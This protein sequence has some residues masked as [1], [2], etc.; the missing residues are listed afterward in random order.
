MARVNSPYSTMAPSNEA[1]RSKSSN[2]PMRNVRAAATPSASSHVSSPPPYSVNP[3]Q[4][5]PARDERTPLLP[6][7]GDSRKYHVSSAPERKKR[8]TLPWLALLVTA[9]VLAV[10]T[11]FTI[12]KPALEHAG[13]PPPPP[14]QEPRPPPINCSL[15]IIGML[16]IANSWDYD[17]PDT[18][19]E[20]R[21]GP[22]RYCSC[23]R[24]GTQSSD[25]STESKSQHDSH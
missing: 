25:E 1:P 22:V 3:P 21:R 16:L 4:Y 7:Y 15:A 6:S 17:M 10:V 5:S 18:N 2:N 9:L 12:V 14:H 13:G 24:V 11:I 8:I 19:A 23:I 20:V